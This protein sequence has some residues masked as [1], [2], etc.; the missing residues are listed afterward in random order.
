MKNLPI[1][2][3]LAIA[4]G[5]TIGLSLLG[6]LLT[7][8]FISNSLRK[9]LANQVQTELEILA[10]TLNEV[11]NQSQA[12]PQE[13][14][15]VNN[16]QSKPRLKISLT[17]TRDRRNLDYVVLLDKTGKVIEATVPLAEG[18]KYDP[19]GVASKT[20]NQEKPFTSFEAVSA[21]QMTP[22]LPPKGE[23]EAEQV[24]MR[25]DTKP[26][27][28]NNQ[29]IGVVILGNLLG[30]DELAVVDGANRRI[31]DGFSLVT[32]ANKQ[33]AVGSLLQDGQNTTTFSDL[34]EPIAEK[35]SNLGDTAT[36]EVEFNNKSYTI[37]ARPILNAEGKAVGQLVRGKPQDS[38]LSLIAETTRLV[39][40]TALGLI[41]VGGIIAVVVGRMVTAPLEKLRQVAEKYN[42]GE[43]D[44]RADIDTED[45]IGI[46]ARAFNQMADSIQQRQADQIAAR[47][48]IEAQSMVLEEEVGKLLEVVSEL[49]SGDL[50][51]EAEVSDQATGLV[52]DTLNRLIEQLS[53]TVA[54]VVETALQVNRSATALEELALTVAQNAQ[55]Q[56]HL[57]EQATQGMINVN[58][59][60]QGASQQA[61]TTGTALASAQAAVAQGQAQVVELNAS[62]QTLQTG[63]EEMVKRIKSLGE[64]V[65]LAKQFVQD[66]RRLASLTQVLAMNASMV[67]ARALEQ[68]EPDQF[69]TVAR[70]FEAIAGQINKLA[71]QTSQGLA[72]LQQRTGFIEIVVSG[73]NQDVSD[74]SN[75]VSSFTA[76]VEETNQAFLN[77]RTV[78]EEV[79][80]LG[81]SV[82][83]SSQ[84][85]A[86]AIEVSFNSIREIEA[87]AERSA[88]Q[89]EITK[90]RSMEMG[91]IAKRLLESMEFFRLP[92]EKQPLLTGKS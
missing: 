4:L 11:T 87:A 45:E 73:I 62:I 78:T 89:S 32:I 22:I 17:E 52:A 18:S 47:S 21:K 49:E 14:E 31:G 84:F 66:Q 81:Q 10:L 67:A 34:P 41:L 36:A 37:G 26:L 42:N 5:G 24:L 12:I 59:L 69:A 9:Q 54:S 39:I 46:L 75:L 86:K 30:Q 20:I 50:T 70:E 82:T 40:L 79:A 2:Y 29:F 1:L 88:K 23:G 85:I 27:F 77:I 35:L 44:Q 19:A 63:T 71:S 58:E 57:V 72:L 74:V 90:Q 38:V 51:V 68:R 16:I 8:N 25:Y 65:D 7:V 83:E 6:F 61:L 53:N 43:Y 76:S 60:A 56:V 92:P 48:E 13:Q 91:E 15:I 64:F 80:K 3:K 55:E 33:L 28:K